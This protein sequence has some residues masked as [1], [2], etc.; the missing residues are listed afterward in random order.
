MTKQI[1]FGLQEA[2]AVL[3]RGEDTQATV[4]A[5][6]IAKLGEPSYVAGS[7]VGTGFTATGRALSVAAGRLSFVYGLKVWALANDLMLIG[8]ARLFVWRM[9]LCNSILQ[10]LAANLLLLY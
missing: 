2:W 7:K 9:D 5:V 1:R 8:L 10:S 6:G 4:V 3:P